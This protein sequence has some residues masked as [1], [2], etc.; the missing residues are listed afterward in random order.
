MINI[1]GGYNHLV[2]RLVD[3]RLSIIPP[4][5]NPNNQGF[6]FIAHMNVGEAFTSQNRVK[7]HRFL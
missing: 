7:K 1:M 3:K 2:E 6:L 4:L 5:D